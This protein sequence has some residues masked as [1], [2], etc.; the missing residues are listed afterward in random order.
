[1]VSK[2][3]DNKYRSGASTNWLTTKCYTV[4]EYEL[5]GV[6]REPGKPALP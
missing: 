4:E 3:R 2:R 1:M 5:L 6:E